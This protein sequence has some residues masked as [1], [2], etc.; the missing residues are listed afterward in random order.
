MIWFTGWLSFDPLTSLV[1]SVIIVWGTWGILRD[2]LNLALNAVPTGIDG[3]EVRGYLECLAGVE[4]IHDLHIWAMS[5][6]QTAL[7]CHLVMP[8]GHP[9][10][11]FV[12][13]VTKQLHDR[14][15]IEHVTLQIERGDVICALKPDHVV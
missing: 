3:A 5:T 1:I 6:T 11:A 7:T 8:A 14:F 13:E 15:E 12:V 2:A 9:P 10:D 4:S